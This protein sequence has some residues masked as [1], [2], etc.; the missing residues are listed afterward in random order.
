[1]YRLKLPGRI[2]GPFSEVEVARMFSKGAISVTT[3]CQRLGLEDW[4]ELDEIFPLLKYGVG[5]SPS[6]ESPSKGSGYFAA[7]FIGV[8]S[9]AVG[10]VVFIFL[11]SAGRPV[12]ISPTISENR[13]S[14]IDPQIAQY[15]PM[16]MQTPDPM[17]R[18]QLV[19]A[20]QIQRPEP[21][22]IP[23]PATSSPVQAQELTL[24]QRRRAKEFQVPIYQRIRMADY[25]GP[26]VTCKIT[27]NNATA[28]FIQWWEGQKP[29]RY[30][31]ITGFEGKNYTP[32]CNISNGVLYFVDTPRSAPGFLIF[33]VD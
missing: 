32:I 33:V 16:Q 15:P 3:L 7:W 21:V 31:K 23:E 4:R 8:G 27:D 24:A 28:I 14:L 1:M 10:L 13:V 12:S 17:A 26:G 18:S 11:T 5:S 20:P 29:V 25:G 19:T 22:I 2:A 30:E 6:F 9:L